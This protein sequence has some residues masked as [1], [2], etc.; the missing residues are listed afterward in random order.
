MGRWSLGSGSIR[1][2]SRSIDIRSEGW[3]DGWMGSFL[4]PSPG[5]ALKRLKQGPPYLQNV[6]GMTKSMD[7]QVGCGRTGEEGGWGEEKGPLQVGSQA[8]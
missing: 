1:C 7:G 2:G 6:E 5:D 3:K 8:A 4:P